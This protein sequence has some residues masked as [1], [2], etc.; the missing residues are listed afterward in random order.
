MN[1][2]KPDLGE[3]YM[4]NTPFGLRMVRVISMRSTA[5]RYLQYSVTLVEGDADMVTF[6]RHE[7]ELYPVTHRE[8]S[9][10]LAR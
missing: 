1:P 9:K 8:L 10:E 4:T 7:T 3:I 2:K 6:S 5:N